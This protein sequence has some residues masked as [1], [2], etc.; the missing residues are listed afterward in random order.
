MEADGIL[1]MF[2]RSVTLHNVR[3]RPYIGDG[4]SSSFSN[5]EKNIPYGPLLL[6]TKSECINHVTKRMG[7]ALRSL[8]KE[9]K[10]TLYTYIALLFLLN[11][12]R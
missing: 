6:V 2:E 12:Y 5:V 11:F 3:Y 4:D 9:Y 1:V 8:Q 10:G 7:T